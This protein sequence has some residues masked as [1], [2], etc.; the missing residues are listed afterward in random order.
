MFAFLVACFAVPL[1]SHKAIVHWNGLV[2]FPMIQSLGFYK[3]SM[4]WDMPKDL[5]SPRR[6]T[7]TSVLQM[8]L[9]GSFFGIAAAAN[10]AHALSLTGGAEQLIRLGL[11]AWGFAAAAPY[12][13]ACIGYIFISFRIR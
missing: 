13:I 2:Y 8:I 6:I 9:I 5:V 7:V 3:A 12:L 10:I 11:L 1:I 4:R